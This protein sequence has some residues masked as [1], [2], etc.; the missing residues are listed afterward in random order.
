MV[1]T[2]DVRIMHPDVYDTLEF[3]ALAFGGIGAGNDF[4]YLLGVGN[5]YNCPLCV[6]GFAAVAEEEVLSELDDF[7]NQSN[8]IVRELSRLSI[9]RSTNDAAVTRVNERRHQNTTTRVAFK[10]WA[11]ELGVVRGTSEEFLFEVT[12]VFVNEPTGPS[13]ATG[14]FDATN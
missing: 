5:D 14:Q 6:W 8:P 1:T 11:E 13:V 12:G 2:K 3:G 7:S 10:S 4:P 9:Y